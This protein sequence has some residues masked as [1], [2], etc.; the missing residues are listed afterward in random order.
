M[1]SNSCCKQK[2]EISKKIIANDSIVISKQTEAQKNFINT[3]LDSIKDKIIASK[4]LSDTTKYTFTLEDV[5]TEGND[6]TAYYI[7][8]RLLKIKLNIYTSMWET[9]LLYTFSNNAIIV[10]E[11]TYNIY[12]KKK[13]I[14]H[15]SY[16]IDFNGIPLEKVESDRIDIFQELKSNIPINL[17]KSSSTKSPNIP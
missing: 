10:N 7:N 1:I 13:L 6:G 8:D 9:N 15:F 2:K 5:G 3:K 12:E 17:I 11:Q 16:K 14:K 4:F